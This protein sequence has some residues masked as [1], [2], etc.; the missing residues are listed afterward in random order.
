MLE[1]TPTSMVAGGDAIARDADGRVVFVAGALPD[2]HVRVEITEGHGRHAKARVVEVLA[3][4]PDRV[5]EP[6]AEVARGCGACGWQHIDLDAQHR[7]KA[8]IV[9]DALVR[10][11][12]VDPPPFSATVALDPWA[13]RT[14]VRASV[15]HGRAGFRRAQSHQ[16]LEV[17]GCLVAHP[18]LVALLVDGRFPGAEEVLLR[19]GARTGER[20]AATTPKRVRPQHLPDDVRNN[21]VHEIAAGRT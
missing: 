11:G 13:F 18:S 17:E 3:A 7:H 4:S 21:H 9:R 6:C 1:L 15:H 5:R 10:L 12:R 2:E 14:T 8:A 19:C 20:L 16:T